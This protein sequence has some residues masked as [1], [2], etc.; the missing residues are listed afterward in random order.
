MLPRL[1]FFNLKASVC[2]NG[3]QDTLTGL[4]TRKGTAA[5]DATYLWGY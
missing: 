2:M 3:I 4:G 1:F 5:S